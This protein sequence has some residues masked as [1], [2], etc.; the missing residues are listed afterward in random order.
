MT[1]QEKWEK[2]YDVL[3]D[4]SKENVKTWLSNYFIE[5]TNKLFEIKDMLKTLKEGNTLD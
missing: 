2:I 4:T 1:T 3:D 5:Q